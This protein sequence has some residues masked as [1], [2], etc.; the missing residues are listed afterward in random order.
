M[1]GDH[2]QDVVGQEDRLRPGRNKGAAAV[3]HGVQ[4]DQVDVVAGAELHARHRAVDQVRARLDA[5]HPDPLADV[6]ALEDLADGALPPSTDR[7]LTAGEQVAAGED[8]EGDGQRQHQ[9]AERG[10]AEEA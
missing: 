9:D 10:E 1:L 4:G 5:K 2:H 3:G 8:D 6:V 7:A